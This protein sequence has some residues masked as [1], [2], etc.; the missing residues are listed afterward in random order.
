MYV[1]SKNVKLIAEGGR[2]VARDRRVGHLERCWS[3]STKSQLCRMNKFWESDKQ[4]GD[5]I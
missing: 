2:V 3:K 4:H 5:Y 1:E